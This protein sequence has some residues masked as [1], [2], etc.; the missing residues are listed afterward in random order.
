MKDAFLFHL[1]IGLIDFL[2]RCLL[3]FMHTGRFLDFGLFE[4]FIVSSAL[5]YNSGGNLKSDSSN[6]V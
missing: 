5:L 1:L 4:I 6:K 2:C 3:P